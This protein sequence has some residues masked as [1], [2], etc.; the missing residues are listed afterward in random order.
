MTFYLLR[1]I[2]MNKL[3]KA[4]GVPLL[5][6]VIVNGIVSI[7]VTLVFQAM[8]TLTLLGLSVVCSFIAILIFHLYTSHQLNRIT[9]DIQSDE[10]L[11]HPMF[12]GLIR[13]AQ[14]QTEDRYL[15][16]TGTVSETIEQ[17]TLSLAATS[18]RVDKL[19]NNTHLATMQSE[20]IAKAAENILT[21]TRQSSESAINA[22][23]F[24]VQTKE[25][26]AQGRVSLQQAI[27]DLQLMMERTKE[28]SGLVSR[29]TESS[30]N[31]QE[32]TQV[33]DTVA[34]QI[35]LLALN[36]AIEAARA[37]EYG[38]GFAVVADEVRKLAEK[39]SAATGQIGGMVNEIGEETIAAANTMSTLAEEVEHGVNSIGE[40][41]VQLDGILQH[42]SALEEQVRAIA[43]GAEDNHLQVDQISTSIATIHKELLNIE[44]EMKG[45]SEQTMVLSD[46]G[47][48]M[49]ESLAETNLDTIHNQLFKVA[50]HAADQIEHVFERA[51]QEREISIDDL[52]DKQYQPVPNTNPTK[53]TT[54]F[55]KFTDQV[56]PDIQEKILTENSSVVFAAA[57]DSN[58]YIPTHNQKFSK[59]LTGNIESDM[60]NNRTKRLFNDRTGSRCGN[61]N[62]KMLIQTYK[63]D[64]GEIMHDISV[65][66]LVQGK[67]WGGFRMGYRA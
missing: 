67:H 46:L 65:P 6:S 57:T 23:Q 16:V 53:Y 44:D 13:S 24:A 55:D 58:G 42:A 12:G 29:L 64:T 15:K 63:R 34:K 62:K 2:T 7:F 33:I 48:G 59:P 39:T 60:A 3:T 49:Y 26:S 38:R 32:I 20:E 28:T 66:I 9:T 18:H 21:T 54:R 10:G 52:F 61:H 19:K 4:I 11:H 30:K 51:V 43:Q 8:E 31:I 25:N 45:V 35:N 50:R 1:E 27:N 40:V 22:A 17:S 14:K 36:A 56:L 47:E 37:G 5:I 41:G